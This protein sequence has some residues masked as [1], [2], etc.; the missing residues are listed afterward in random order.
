MLPAYEVIISVTELYPSCATTSRCWHQAR[1]GNTQGALA[2]SNQRLS[3][4]SSMQASATPHRGAHRHRCCTPQ[5]IA[6]QALGDVARTAICSPRVHQVH[7]AN[8]QRH[9]RRPALQGALVAPAPADA[10]LPAHRPML[11]HHVRLIAEVL[12]QLPAM[13]VHV[14][15][16]ASPAAAH[17]SS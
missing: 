12:C 4:G 14:S 10:H 15:R 2:Q 8:A 17:C 3:L 5:H 9:D 11:T 6:H 16:A 1:S 13:Y 7:R